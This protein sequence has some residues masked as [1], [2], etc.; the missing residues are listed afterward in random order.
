MRYTRPCVREWAF[1]T[2]P[3]I[4]RLSGF[5][6]QFWCQLDFLFPASRC[7]ALR[8]KMFAKGA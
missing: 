8:G 7:V 1:Y 4:L 5:W 3:R 2:S 6:C